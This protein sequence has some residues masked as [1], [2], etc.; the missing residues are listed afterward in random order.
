VAGVLAISRRRA[1]LAMVVV[2]AAG[3]AIVMAATF[4][5][6]NPSRAYYGTDSRA[7]ELL[8]GAA[9]ALVL[10]EWSRLVRSD[11]ARAVARVAWLPV[12]LVLAVFVLE[13]GDQSPHYYRAGAVAFALAVA[14]MLWA[15]EAAPASFAG[16]VLSLPPVVWVGLISYGLYLWHWPMLVWIGPGGWSR[17]LAVVGA[18][19]GA[20]ALSYYLV[21]RPI[22]AGRVPRLTAPR[23]RFVA[24][25]GGA[26]LLLAG[27]IARATS[28]SADER[29]LG[30]VTDLSDV[31]CPGEQAGY[32][33]PAA[34]LMADSPDRNA[35]VIATAGDSTSRALTPGL[36]ALAT[37][38]GWDYVQAGRDGCS[39]LP[40]AL[41]N[42]AED[43]TS[44]DQA[45]ACADAAEEAIDSAAAQFH[46]DLWI[47]SD[48]FLLAD[49]ATP[50]GPLRVGDPQR[51]ELIVDSMAATLDRMG[52]DGAAIAVL[53]IPP[54]G[55]PVDCAV[56][57]GSDCESPQY[58]TAEDATA[59]ANGL[60]RLAVQRA[61]AN[62]ALVSVTDVICPGGQCVASI[63]DK[64]V[65]YDGVHFTAGYSREIAP[66]IVR[67][68]EAAGLAPDAQ[69]P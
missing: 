41:A 11:R 39:A 2:A 51:D 1:L 55:P 24:V 66:V 31:A 54:P 33:V 61:H 6:L 20:A 37:A 62:A 67:R 57:E 22:R 56:D 38:R 52:R 19:F 15:I 18:T 35:P 13:L 40:L 46:P 69:R 8:I 28:I 60:Q 3:S 27:G 4:D 45:N 49:M 65:R 64:L 21:E 14:A 43:P 68:A 44:I 12:A 7:F 23:W 29:L 34:C 16:R 9:L 59:H 36:D 53:E 48:R 30:Q 47:V 25:M 63:G 10:I 32:A 58:S 17:Q 42:D 5:S 50:E 26:A